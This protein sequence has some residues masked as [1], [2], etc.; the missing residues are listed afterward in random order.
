MY[1]ER[2]RQDVYKFYD[3]SNR[4]IGRQAIANRLKDTFDEIDT[5][6]TLLE[7]NDCIRVKL[8]KALGFAQQD[9][10][11]KTDV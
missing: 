11:C 4:R 8:K 2:R 9:S 7:S 1:H 10:R 6:L 3:A 5:P